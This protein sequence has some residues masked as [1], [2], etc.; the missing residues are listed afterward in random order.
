M[1]GPAEPHASIRMVRAM[2]A[3]SDPI[4][5]LGATDTKNRLDAGK[6]CR[7]WIEVDVP[8]AQASQYQSRVDIALV[9]IRQSFARAAQPRRAQTLS[10]G[11]TVA[12]LHATQIRSA[13]T[14]ETM[15]VIPEELIDR[16]S[17]NPNTLP[18]EGEA[19]DGAHAL[20]EKN[21]S[22]AVA[23]LRATRTSRHQLAA[24]VLNC[25]RRC[26]TDVPLLGRAQ[27]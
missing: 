6:H 25:Y 14:D 20:A 19:R 4:F 15:A 8:P 3:H 13:S 7:T 17:L 5:F 27:G 2:M 11:D 10:R 23:G 18:T 26:G 24:Q 1:A 9:R 22:S 16:V 12:I 21:V